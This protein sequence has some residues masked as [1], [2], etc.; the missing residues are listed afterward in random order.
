MTSPLEGQ[1]YWPSSGEVLHAKR[2]EIL[3][4]LKDDRHNTVSSEKMVEVFLKQ[5]QVVQAGDQFG[6]GRLHVGR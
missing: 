3:T 1:A 4:M 5:G 2:R 6:L